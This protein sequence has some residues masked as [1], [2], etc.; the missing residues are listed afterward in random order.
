MGYISGFGTVCVTLTLGL[1]ALLTSAAAT[2]SDN[3][4]L[5]LSVSGLRNT[6]GLVV[7]CLTANPKAFPDCR[8]DASAHT[9]LVAAAYAK[10]IHFAGVEPGTYAVSLIHDEN[11]NGK[12]DVA[13]M[14]PNEGF[15]FS[16]NPVVTFGPPKFRNASFLVGNGD[17]A[18]SVKVKYML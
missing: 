10:N 4:A 13:V 7:V 2:S 9:R 16:R 5:E 18:Q 14:I 15:G 17:T 8:K 6:K 3:P 12:L 11:G 1:A